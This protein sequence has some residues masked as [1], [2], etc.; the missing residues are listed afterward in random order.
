MLLNYPNDSS[1]ARFARLKQK[2]EIPAPAAIGGDVGIHGVWK[3][4]DDMIEL[5]V[6]WTDGCIA[7][8]N[9]DIDDLYALI[10]VGCRVYI[11]K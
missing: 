3:G 1:Y 9:K 6:N 7:L 5:G 4:G 8:K 11:R 10:D 2:G